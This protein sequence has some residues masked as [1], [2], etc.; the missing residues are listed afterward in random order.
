MHF[1]NTS[2]F[3]YGPVQDYSIKMNMN[4]DTNR[5]WTWGVN[6]QTPIAA[7]A[8]TGVLQIASDFHT[9]GAATV[10]EELSS[11]KTSYTNIELAT[12]SWSGSH[13]LLFNANKNVTVNGSL[14]ATGNTKYSNNQGAYSGG[15]GGIFF[16][17]NGGVMD[18]NISPASGSTSAG[19]NVSWGTPKMRINRNGEVGIGT[20]DIDGYRLS[21]EGA[22]RSTEVKVEASPWPDYVF[23]SNYNLPSLESVETYINEHGHLPEV[24]SA[25]VVEE[26]GIKLGEMNAV[27]LK[28]IEELTLYTL[29]QQKEIASL[30]GE[31]EELRINNDELSQEQKA[32]SQQLN[33]LLTRIENLE[34]K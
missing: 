15:A 18:F 3:H 24:P 32:N 9:L 19:T 16:F 30:K 13:A 5:G 31:N 27:L 26:E 25:E 7:L 33:E 10:S 34:K 28:K 8:T 6:G 17:A 23:A 2:E 22:I 29:S 11:G 12:H 4:S 1:G 21:V 20:T 14:G